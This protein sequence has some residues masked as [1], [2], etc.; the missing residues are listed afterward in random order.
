M[1]TGNVFHISR[2]RLTVKKNL[3]ALALYDMFLTDS[4]ALC[5]MSER[6]HVTH[7]MSSHT[8]FIHVNTVIE[9]D[10]ITTFFHENDC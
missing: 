8:S 7:K 2:T 4:L 9:N 1:T 5:M 10:F 6:Q 3:R